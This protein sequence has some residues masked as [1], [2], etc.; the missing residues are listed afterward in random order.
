M[1]GVKTNL[2]Q[3]VRQRLSEHGMAITEESLEFTAE[4]YAKKIMDNPELTVSMLVD[5]DIA[6]LERI[7]EE[8]HSREEAV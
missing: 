6:E 3:F 5:D 2:I 1:N 4:R 8:V 7:L